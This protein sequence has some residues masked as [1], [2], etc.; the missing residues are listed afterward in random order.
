MKTIIP[1]L[2]AGA[3][4]AGLF[5]GAAA[6]AQTTLKM[7]HSY[8]PGNIWYEAGEA[9]KKAIEERTG[10]KVKVAIDHSRTTGDWPQQIEGLLI[11]TNDIVIQSVGALDRYNIIAGI[12]AYPY[13][14]HDLDHFKKVFYGPLGK[15]LYDEIAK[16][17]RFKI[18]GAGYRGARPLTARRNWP[19]VAD[20]KA[21][22]MRVPPLK[23]YRLTWEYLG[24]SPVPMGAAELFTSLQQGVVDGQ[25]NPLEVV[26][27]LKLNE[28]QKYVI[29]T[30][31]II[32]AM[33]FIFSDQRFRS[34]PADLQKIL[35]EEGNRVMLEAT[36]EMEKL[37]EKLKSDLIA[38]GM[39]FT[40][41]NRDEWRGKARQ[42]RRREGEMVRVPHREPL[43][44]C[45]TAGAG[46][47][48][49]GA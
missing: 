15:E 24:A 33:T 2:A 19:R 23:M 44:E 49:P 3:L 34:L 18:I 6:A 29:E 32:G 7:A 16:K 17:T 31:H 42:R 36:A 27:M 1:I 26:E 47:R 28:V 10:G 40:P 38:K 37:E 11:G 5:A 13:L 35:Q 41:V 4:A 12:E 25:E 45:G 22:K 30:A 21:L 9:Y 8:T 14:I 46:D 43:H 20:L 48:L 39:T